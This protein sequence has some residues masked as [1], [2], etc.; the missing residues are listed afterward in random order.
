MRYERKPEHDRRIGR[1]DD[2]SGD[3]WID[4]KTGEIVYGAVG[5]DRNRIVYEEEE[6]A[7]ADYEK[8]TMRGF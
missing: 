4:S 1:G 8:Q 3:A 6:R 2:F 5:R 7:M